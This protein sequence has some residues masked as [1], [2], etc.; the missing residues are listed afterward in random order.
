MP[1]SSS[2]LAQTKVLPIWLVLISL[3][4]IHRNPG[5]FFISLQLFIISEILRGPK[6][7]NAQN[8]KLIFLDFNGGFFYYFPTKFLRV[9]FKQILHIVDL[10]DNDNV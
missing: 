4:V 6:G 3:F 7:T 2:H 9:I 10:F 5:R 8:D 1:Q